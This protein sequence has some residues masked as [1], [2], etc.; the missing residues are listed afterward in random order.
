MAKDIQLSTE[1]TKKAVQYAITH[2]A[3]ERRIL[4]RTLQNSVYESDT[5]VSE[6]KKLTHEISVFEAYL[7][8][9]DKS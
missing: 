8:E 2:L 5:V 1:F 3:E 4:Q 7:E 9:L 6:Y